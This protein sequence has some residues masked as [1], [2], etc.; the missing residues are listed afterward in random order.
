[1]VDNATGDPL[2]VSGVPLTQAGSTKFVLPGAANINTGFA[3][4]RTDMRLFNYGTV[5]QTATLTFYPLG[6]GTPRSAEVLAKVGEVLALDNVVKT[7]FGGDNTGGAVHVTT[8]Q[9]ASFIV[10][11]RTYNQTANGTLGQ[12]INAVSVEQGI[13][14]GGRS[15]QILQIEDSVRYRANIGVTELSGKPATVEISVILPDSKITPIV[16]VP[17]AANE[18]RQLNVIRELNLG[19]VYNARVSVKVI[20]GDGRVTAFASLIDEFTGDP[21]FIQGQ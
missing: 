19:N 21:A 7:L 10:S 8:P 9:P 12:F 6:N 2:L 15:L 20:G 16:E 3:D 5:P 4:W 18:F 1:V 17:L 11:G 14:R 13:A